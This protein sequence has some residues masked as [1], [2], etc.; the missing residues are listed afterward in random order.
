MDQQK[1]YTTQDL[2]PEH[3][4]IGK[5]TNSERHLRQIGVDHQAISKICKS[6]SIKRLHLVG[7]VA[8][9]ENNK[10][11]DVDLIVV[12]ERYGSA[13]LQYMDAKSAFESAFNKKVDLIEEEAL[14][15]PY[16]RK[17]MAE[18]KVLLYETL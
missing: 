12:F 4:K 13:L 7:S 11:S 18:D 8:R 17:S 16:L 9:E 3:V 2:A 5:S 15:N 1:H 14:Q 6:F 10:D